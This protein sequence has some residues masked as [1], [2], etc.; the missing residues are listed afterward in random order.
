MSELTV[1]EEKKRKNPLRLLLSLLFIL[2]IF[3]LTTLVVSGSSLHIPYRLFAVLTGSM[4]PVI[5]PGDL[6]IVSKEEKYTVGDVIAFQTAE[7]ESEKVVT[8]RIVKSEDSNTL[9]TTKGDFN[10]VTDVDKVGKANIIGKYR[11]R[12]PLLG[13]PI[14]FIKTPT[15]VTL[16]VVI[17]SVLI[18]QHHLNR[19][20]NEISKRKLT[21]MTA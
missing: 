18:I 10:S 21:P 15:G 4:K 11:Y 6:I 5:Q 8:H 14:Q 20:K 12:I 1:I 13:Y 2:F 9:F 16:L 3:L 7:G 19:I 17:P